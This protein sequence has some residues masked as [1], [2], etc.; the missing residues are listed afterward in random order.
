MAAGGQ[1][2]DGYEPCPHCQGQPDSPQP[3]IAILTYTEV[4]NLLSVEHQEMAEALAQ[5]F[6]N[7]LAHMTQDSMMRIALEWISAQSST[8]SR[9]HVAV[10]A[11]LG[12]YGDTFDYDRWYS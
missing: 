5:P 2:S 11:K 12:L 10:V 8:Q 7:E 1:G 4:M 9:R 3:D 6:D